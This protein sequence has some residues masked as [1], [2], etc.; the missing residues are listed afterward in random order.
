MDVVM[1]AEMSAETSRALE[2]DNELA[3]CIVVVGVV[4]GGRQAKSWLSQPSFILSLLMSNLPTA[5]LASLA[6]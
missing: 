1:S 2:E 6:S 5:S 4:G 3:F